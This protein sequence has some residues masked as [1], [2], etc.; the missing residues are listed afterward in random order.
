MLTLYNLGIFLYRFG[1]RVAA[2]IIPKARL[3]IEG[4]R[5][6]FSRL[7][8]EIAGLNKNSNAEI[9]WFHCAS[10]GEFEQ[11]R[12]V[13]EAFKNHHPHKKILLTFFSPSGYMVRKNWE[14]ADIVFYLPMD[15]RKNATRFL[16]IVKPQMA[17]F[18][19]Y[20]YWFNFLDQLF[21]MEVP[22]YFISAR[23]LPGH[24]FFGWY[25]AWFRKYL[26]QV[27]WFFLQDGPSAQMLKGYGINN[28]SITGD[29]RF[30]RV[31]QVMSHATQ[32]PLVEQFKGDSKVIM[33]GSSWPPDEDLLI[34]WITA[35]QT[36][37]KFIIAPH[38]TDKERIN[39]LVDHLPLPAILYSELGTKPPGDYKILVIDCIGIL[40][41]LYQYATVAIIGGGFGK[42]IHNILEATAFGVPVLFG[43]NFHKFMEAQELV[44]LG[45]AF[46]VQTASDFEA[47]LKG[48]LSDDDRYSQISLVCKNYVETGRGA[49]DQIMLK[50]N[51]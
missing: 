10:L 25:G 33:A 3:W 15:T 19:K 28:F 39:S 6:L 35:H 47:V 8:N 17:F 41:H 16:Q 24:Y 36:P 2:L 1:L 5:N 9:A 40:T 49:T 11:G 14:G 50:I 21:L 7:E 44:K 48:L 37:V 29:T 45:G 34:H 51:E 30:D 38:E 4:R 13:M 32:F 23:F 20:E 18:I 43:P 27:T 12:P 31:H 26:R 22:V 42:G 46:P